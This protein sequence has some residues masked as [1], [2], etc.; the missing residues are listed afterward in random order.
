MSGCE[1]VVRPGLK[2]LAREL[3]NHSTLAEALL[4]PHL[5]GRQRQGFDFHRQKPIDRYI[6]DFLS[7]ELMLAVEIDG[8]SHA[9]KGPEDEQ[10]QRRLEC[11]GIRFLRFP[12]H[13]VKA[14]VGVVVRAID[15]WIELNPPK[16]QANTPRPP[17]T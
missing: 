2:R 11:L 7:S 15:N 6:V 8:S 1:V 16:A 12:D 9:L 13:Q 14:D 4:W 3:R 5:K 17:A 10:R